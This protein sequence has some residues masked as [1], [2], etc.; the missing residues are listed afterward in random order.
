M[1]Q[2]LIVSVLQQYGCKE[3][4]L[5]GSRAKGLHRENSDIDLIV[6]YNRE[7]D[8]R[9]IKR[10][11]KD[12]PEKRFI[13]LHVDTTMTDENLQTLLSWAKQII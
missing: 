7:M 5:T 12:L 10:A 3:A 1:M 11:L 9:S 2:E 4:Y 8:L 13:D 6:I